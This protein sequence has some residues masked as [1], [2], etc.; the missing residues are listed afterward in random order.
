MLFTVR[1]TC[2]LSFYGEVRYNLRDITTYAKCRSTEHYQRFRFKIIKSEKP[3][4]C[5]IIASDDEIK[6]VHEDVTVAQQQQL[7]RDL[8]GNRRTN[9]INKLQTSKAV[10]ILAEIQKSTSAELLRD[11]HPQN[12]HKLNTFHKAVIR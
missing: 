3:V 5:A 8:K 4:A 9:L 2:I 11:G 12:L 10:E 7:F 6:Y 1:C